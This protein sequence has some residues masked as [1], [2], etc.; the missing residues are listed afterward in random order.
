LIE[1]R[2]SSDEDPKARKIAQQR[3]G[4]LNPSTGKKWRQ[5][6]KTQP[7]ILT[8]IRPLTDNK[9]LFLLVSAS[10]LAVTGSLLPGVRQPEF[11]VKERTEET[12][13]EIAYATTIQKLLPSF[14]RFR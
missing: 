11:A 7:V 1:R 3:L 10:L 2:L 12:I 4:D 9:P 6:A 5:T 8:W 14:N 13:A